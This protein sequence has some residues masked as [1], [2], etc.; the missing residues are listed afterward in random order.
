MNNIIKEK[1]EEM[2]KWCTILNEAAYKKNIVVHSDIGK[3]P[4]EAVFGILPR[5]EV[6]SVSADTTEDNGNEN[7]PAVP[8]L[9]S[10]IPSKRKHEENDTPRKKLKT[11]INERQLN[12]NVKMTESRQKGPTFHTNEYV[13]IKIDK[14]DK[15]S[16][17]H[18]N[19]LMGKITEVENDYAKIV[20]KF[21]KLK[22]YI[23][24]NR[25]NKCTAT[26]ITLDYTKEITF[27]AACR[28]AAEQ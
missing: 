12:Y 9:D 20:T 14:V 27:S 24:T 15:T 11:D 17:I 25:L 28:K 18:P 26:N 8:V 5:K 6:H 16:P 19:V 7:N 4:Y 2:D 10:P 13:S 22:T 21:G 1:N 23:S 3:T